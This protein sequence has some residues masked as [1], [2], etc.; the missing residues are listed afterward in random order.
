M[1]QETKMGNARLAAIAAAIAFAVSLFS[2][3]VRAEGDRVNGDGVKPWAPLGVSLI[4]SGLQVPDVEHSIF[5]AML[6]IGEGE[7]K[8]AYFL[9]AGLFNIVDRTM[10]GVQVGLYN[11]TKT[12]HGVQ[13]GFMNVSD[14]FYGIQ[15]GVLN[16][17]STVYGLQ[18]GLI[19]FGY[20]LRGVQI[21]LLNVSEGDGGQ[22]CMIGGF[23]I[24]P[25]LNVRF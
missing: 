17:S 24:L 16:V 1:K 8:D 4:A 5:G 18:V 6:N 12:G 13:G 3:F 7:V 25:I 15:A 20:D 14:K 9:N 10:A 2:C 21:G 22:S 23:T 19:N 11:E